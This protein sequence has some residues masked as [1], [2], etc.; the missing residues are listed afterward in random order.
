MEAG[1][2]EINA[3]Q[4]VVTALTL[5]H[6]CSGKAMIGD[7]NHALLLMPATALSTQDQTKHC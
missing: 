1:V 6:L 4:F 7:K 3:V 2:E 5:V